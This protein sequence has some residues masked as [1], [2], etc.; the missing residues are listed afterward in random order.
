M[1]TGGKKKKTE[2]FGENGRS[3]KLRLLETTSTVNKGNVPG[4]P[5]VKTPHFQC[6]G[7]RFDPWCKLDPTCCLVWPKNFF[8]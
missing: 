2:L 1:N 3:T 7:C 4:D 6:K 8:N 5:V